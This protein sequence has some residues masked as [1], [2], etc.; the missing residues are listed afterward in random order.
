M[1]RFDYYNPNVIRF[2]SKD[3]SC[4]FDAMDGSELSCKAD[5]L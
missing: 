1:G 5:N 2:L 4:W 3:K